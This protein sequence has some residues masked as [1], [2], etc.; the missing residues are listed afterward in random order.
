MVKQSCGFEKFVL[1]IRPDLRDTPLA[2]VW[3][4]I[5]VSMPLKS[6]CSYNLQLQFASARSSFLCDK[7]VWFQDS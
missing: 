2:Y 4:T 3:Q 7:E 5:E 6:G 1:L